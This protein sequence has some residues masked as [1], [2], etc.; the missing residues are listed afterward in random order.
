METVGYIFKEPDK[1]LNTVRVVYKDFTVN[2]LLEA[3][4]KMM[5]KNESMQRKKDDIKEIPKDVYTVEEKVTF[6]RET[7]IEK[8]EILFE[9]LFTTYLPKRGRNDFS[10]AFRD[11]ETPV[12]KRSAGIHV[13]TDY[14]I[15]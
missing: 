14:D 13:R 6:I 11:V 15:A 9:N 10:G 5:L 2:A 1:S 4:A 8:K 7:L 3:F 12:Y